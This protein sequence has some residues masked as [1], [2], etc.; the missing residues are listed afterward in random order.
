MDSKYWISTSHL[1]L[2]RCWVD[3]PLILPL[4]WLYLFSPGLLYTTFPI[5]YANSFQPKTNCNRKPCSTSSRAFI[6]QTLRTKIFLY[7]L[8]GAKECKQSIC[9]Q[10]IFCNFQHLDASGSG[11]CCLF[12]GQN[13]YLA[14]PVKVC[15]ITLN[16][17]FCSL[18]F[19]TSIR[20]N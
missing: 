1:L 9:E 10:L 2:S 17:C 16:K 4:L 12:Q 13:D 18:V 3:K 6:M 14:N 7:V 5:A 20:I 15:Y 19:E 11:L 8:S